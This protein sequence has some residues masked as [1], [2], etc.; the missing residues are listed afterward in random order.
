MKCTIPEQQKVILIDEIGGYDVIKYED[1]PVPSISEE[2]LLIKNKY[3][4]VNYIESYFRKGIYPC[5]KP[6]VLGRKRRG[7]L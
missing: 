1:Y 6:Y 4:G 7:P 5:E 2:E 3:T